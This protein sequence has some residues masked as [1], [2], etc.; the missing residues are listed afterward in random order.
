[1]FATDRTKGGGAWRI[2]AAHS[3]PAGLHIGDK[4]EFCC[5]SAGKSCNWKLVYELSKEG[6]F[7][8]GGV[9]E[10]RDDK[11]EVCHEHGSGASPASGP[12]AQP[13]TSALPPD[14]AELGDLLAASGLSAKVIMQVFHTKAQRDGVTITWDYGKIY[15]R[16]Q[17][18]CTAE[19][20]ATGFIEKLITRGRSG[21]PP[22]L[23]PP[24]SPSRAH[25]QSSRMCS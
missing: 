4:Q 16:F 17:R 6:W 21:E 12:T 24:P 11:G 10:H 25:P 7:L 18:A 5:S 23:C 19:L 20:D 22:S 15:D 3:R 1:M 14:F 8:S 9:L 13:T 2:H